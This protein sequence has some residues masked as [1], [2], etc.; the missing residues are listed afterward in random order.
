MI[1]LVFLYDES[2]LIFGL[3]HVDLIFLNLYIWF[4]LIV[5]T[6]FNEEKLERYHL[7][8]T[9][10][11]KVIISLVAL[12]FFFRIGNIF[13]PINLEILV[14]VYLHTKSDFIANQFICLECNR[15][16]QP[17]CLCNIFLVTARQ[18]RFLSFNLSE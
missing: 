13:P 15:Q 3:V 8:D 2:W 9:I 18:L 12:I 7:Y 11:E 16:P 6:W 5:F 1:A 10:K 14:N 4:H 17:V